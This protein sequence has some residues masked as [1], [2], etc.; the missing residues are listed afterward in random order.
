LLLRHRILIAHPEL[1]LFAAGHD[2]GLIVFKLERERPA[3]CVYENRLYYVKDKF[4]RMYDFANGS[5]V[6]LMDLLFQGR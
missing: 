1:N 3:S 4:I 2:T 6:P 5:D